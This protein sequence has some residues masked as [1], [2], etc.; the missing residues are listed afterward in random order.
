MANE[1]PDGTPA[2]NG[3]PTIIQ[4][5]LQILIVRAERFHLHL[6]SLKLPLELL[7]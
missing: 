4:S 3:I 6:Q 7:G 5:H 2:V 1:Y